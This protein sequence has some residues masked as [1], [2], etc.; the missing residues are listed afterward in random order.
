[1][2]IAP[3]EGQA[4]VH[5]SSGGSSWRSSLLGR[6]KLALIAPREGQAGVHRS[7]GGSSLH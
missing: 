3:R 5:R 2:F 7:S 6:V 1:M 4:G